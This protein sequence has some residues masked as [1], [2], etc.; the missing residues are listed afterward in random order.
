MT[1]TRADGLSNCIEGLGDPEVDTRLATFR[2][3]TIQPSVEELEQEWIQNWM[4]YV[5][6]TLVANTMFRS[7][8]DL[9]K[10]T[11]EIDLAAVASYAEGDLHVRADGSV[12]T[13]HGLSWYARQLKVQGDKLGGAALYPI[14]EDGMD[15]REPLNVH[16]I[17]RV[18]GWE[19]FDRREIVP[20]ATGRNSEP[21]FWMLADVIELTKAS[22]GTRTLRPGDVI[23]KSR[24]RRYIGRGD[25]SRREQR[26]RQWWGLS[27]LELNKRQRLAAERASEHLS[28]FIA[29]AGYMHYQVAEL[30][31]LLR[32]KDE[33]GNRIGEAALKDRMRVQR[34]AM[35]NL[36]MAISDG[37]RQAYTDVASG[38]EIPARLPDKLESINESSG[39]LSKIV[40]NKQ[41][42]W[43]RGAQLPESIAFS[44]T[45]DTGLR[46]GENGGDWQ[47]FAGD[48]KAEQENGFCGT[49]TLNW[50]Y[51]IVFSSKRGPTGGM[52]PDSWQIQWRPL[53]IP[54]PMEVA[55][56]AKAQ[57]EADEVRIRSNVVEAAEVRHQRMVLGDVDGPLRVEE[58]VGDQAAGV[59]PAQVGIATAVLEGGMAVGRGETTPEFFAAYLQSIDEP[60]FPPDR[61]T[62]LAEA[63]RPKGAPVPIPGEQSLASTDGSTPLVDTAAVA[64]ADEPEP[65]SS[66]PR[67]GDLMK[68]GDLAEIITA[69]FGISQGSQSI[70]AM[71]RR[72]GLRRWKV[73]TSGGYSKAEIIAAYEADVA[74]PAP[75]EPA[76]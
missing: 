31:E 54:T 11:P 30:D 62:Q 74:E 32:S 52:L 18:V 48:V 43:A 72:H 16:R 17:D 5:E 49:E 67:P 50:M 51:T 65:F 33:N 1:D 40:E 76:E 61:A 3:Y 66:D 9:V 36:G 71:A 13:Q 63:A 58:D 64:D 60:R 20:V 41:R 14:L 56:I 22:Q 69:R 24:L 25:L 39:D 57:A 37:G 19:V 59:G 45:G 55:E 46:G 47:K 21:E 53:R 8:Y 2:T 4:A 23:H 29:R 28:T 10:V 12:D 44:A 15:P 75:V 27:V 6:V 26:Y 68:P 73:G 34:N 35:S 38:Q 70:N 7:G 42:E